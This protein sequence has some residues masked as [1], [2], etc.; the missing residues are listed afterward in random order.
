MVT[1]EPG[2]LSTLGTS[3]AFQTLQRRTS[4]GNLSHQPSPQNN[5]TLQRLQP[6]QYGNPTMIKI[7]V[8][9]D[10]YYLLEYR[11][12]RD[13]NIDSLYAV[14]SEGRNDFPTYLEV[15]KTYLPGRIKVSDSTGVLLAVDNYD[16][17]LPGAGILIWHIDET[18]VRQK[19]MQNTIN[20]DRNNR[21]VDV[22]EADG[23]QDIGY[24]YTVVEPGFQ[25]ELGTW[26]D[27]WFAENPA[28]LYQNAFSATSAPNTR[29]NR[30]LANSHIALENFSS[31]TTRLMS[32]N[33]RRDYFVKG[34][35]V[36]LD[37][38]K[39]IPTHSNPIAVR[40]ESTDQPAV[41]TANSR[42]EILAVTADGAGILD[43]DDLILA[44]FERSEPLFLSFADTNDNGQADVLVA[45]GSSGQIIA[46]HF[47]DQ[48]FDGLLDT[49]F[50]TDTGQTLSALPVVQYPYFYVA[51][52]QGNLFR[53]SY[54]GQLDSIFTFNQPIAAFT[55]IDKSNVAVT[56]ADADIPPYPPAVIDLDGDGRFETIRY[57]TYT[58]VQI[59]DEEIMLADS[60]VG[61][62]V[63]SDLDDD[64]FYELVL[65]TASGVY[66]YNF[67]RT[68]VTNFPVWP[69]LRADEQLVGSPLVFDA[70]G[71]AKADILV[72]TTRGQ[73]FAYDQRA[74][75][76]P[77][78]PYSTGGEVFSSPVA[79][80]I[81]YDNQVELLLVNREAFLF[82]W[83][84]NAGED[85]NRTWW[86]QPFSGFDNNSFYP[87]IL[88]PEGLPVSDLLPAQRAY[89]YPNPNTGNKTKIRYYLSEDA[90]VDIKIFDL[91]GDLVDAFAGP[92]QGK[93][94][95]EVS[96]DLSGISSGIYL[97]RI[98]ASSSGTSAVKI[99][100]IMV[101]N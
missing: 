24:E 62:G 61:S 39:Q 56:I 66:V 70:D 28:P 74:E 6:G 67:N 18:V 16:W 36:Q 76:L 21:A 96:C 3:L 20:D 80:D 43:P 44:R 91:A 83:V 88:Q 41:F 49:L 9:S 78:Y 13:V 27:F 53:F 101:I 77:G 68:F 72:A 17:G 95:N 55:V 98:E 25:S 34:F 10:E 26:L 40:L 84:Q 69:V 42:G 2:F 47:L 51:S 75:I 1:S 93:I 82:A 90:R 46:Y 97:C 52:E 100:K 38:S 30:T 58:R 11:G 31:N 92:G 14:L 50:T 59:D 99:I 15:L 5:L 8:N 57:T 37:S 87:L 60:L 23:S 65:N 71:D 86:Y 4:P 32:F 89:V 12:D 94:D 85:D 29:A 22:E 19:S 54:S 45:A 35:P 48:N 79:I 64:G 7:P 33:Y 73:I 81:N 63:F